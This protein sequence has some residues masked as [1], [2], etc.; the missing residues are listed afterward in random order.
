MGGGGVVILHLV[1]TVIGENVWRFGGWRGGG[2][3]RT[4][5]IGACM[6]YD[7]HKGYG[8]SS[9]HPCLRNYYFL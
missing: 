7:P 8:Y 2:C 1:N 5:V 9:S 6:N 3:K 4:A